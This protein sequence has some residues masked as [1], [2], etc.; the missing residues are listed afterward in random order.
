VNAVL[1]IGLVVALFHHMQLGLQVVIEDY[2][3]SEGTRVIVVLLMKAAT[4]LLGL[5][6]LISV[7]RLAF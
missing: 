7:L 6:A 1:M 3:H 4:V 2:I 5:A